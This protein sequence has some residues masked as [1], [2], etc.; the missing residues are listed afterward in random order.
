METDIGANGSSFTGHRL[1]KSLAAGFRRSGKLRQYFSENEQERLGV[2]MANT[3]LEMK[4]LQKVNPR[5]SGERLRFKMHDLDKMYKWCLPTEQEDD[6]SPTMVDASTQC[7]PDLKVGLISII[8]LLG[9]VL[10]EPNDGTVPSGASC[11]T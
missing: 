8:I 5:Y 2:V 3:L 11:D 1:V 4:L 9:T 6:A 10:H 7:D